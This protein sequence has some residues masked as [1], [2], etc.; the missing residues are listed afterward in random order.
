MSGQGSHF[1]Q[2]RDG[3]EGVLHGAI[4]HLMGNDNDFCTLVAGVELDDGLN[5][6]ALLAK[7]AAD[8][9]DYARASSVWKRT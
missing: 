7:T 6:D 5:R 3:L 8:A 2:S 4:A 9:T 1:R